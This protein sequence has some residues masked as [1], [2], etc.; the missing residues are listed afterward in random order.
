LPVDRPDGSEASSQPDD[1]TK[2]SADAQEAVDSLLQ[3]SVGKM[4]LI[5]RRFQ[6]NALSHHRDVYWDC[7]ERY[8]S[9]WFGYRVINHPENEMSTTTDLVIADH[10]NDWGNADSEL[11]DGRRILVVHEQMTCKQYHKQGELSVGM[12]CTPIGPFK[13]ARSIISLLDQ[14]M[15]SR[16]PKPCNTSDR[17]TQTPLASPEDRIATNGMPMT[18]YG[19]SMPVTSLLTTVPAPTVAPA[20]LDPVI[21]STPQAYPAKDE[22][23][24]QAIPSL[25][26]M[27]LRMPSRFT[28]QT[29]TASSES[30]IPDQRTPNDAKVPAAPSNPTN[31]LHILAVDDNAVNLQLIH[32]YLLKRKMDTIVTART[33]VEAVDAVREEANKGKNFDIIFMDISMPVMDG[34]EATRLIRSFERSFGHQSVS[35]EAGCYINL[36]EETEKVEETVKV[37]HRM[38][39]HVVALTGLASRRDRDEAEISGFDDFLTK[40]IAFGKIGELLKRLSE[41]KSGKH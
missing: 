20:A 28:K 10:E 37:R 36:E 8:C 6:D 31:A 18:D 16:A 25:A 17:G 14:E 40:P 38:R 5:V 34:F 13:L 21:A 27:S 11:T 29:Q 26:A 12:I 15:P 22:G 30:A 9:D 2:L 35:E 39:A 23:S 24:K 3:R 19:F 7:I 4:V 33:G 1:L 41:E 32:R